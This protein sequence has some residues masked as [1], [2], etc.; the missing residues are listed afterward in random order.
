MS[1]LGI[2]PYIDETKLATFILKAQDPDDGGIADR[3]DDMADV[4][5]TFFGISGLS[6]LGCLPSPQFGQIDPVYALPVSVVRRLG[7]QAQVRITSGRVV[8]ERLK[9]YTVVVDDP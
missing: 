8:E 6:L 7:L 5:H 4:F 3:P 1:L 2:I 9:G